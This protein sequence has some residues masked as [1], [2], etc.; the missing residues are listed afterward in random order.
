M[1]TSNY[2]V[3]F[4][5]FAERHYIKS[6]E[7]KYKSN[8]YKTRGDVVE[9]C[10]RIDTMIQLKRADLIAIS[11]SHKLVKLDFAVEG[12]KMSPKASGNRCILHIDEQLHIVKI[13][14]VYSKNDISPPNET[15]KWKTIIKNHFPETATIF[16][17]A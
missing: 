17:F 10:K 6:F 14:L 9:V 5:T 1:E 8:W 7:K 13:L 2:G 16:S 4:E 15:T 11:G 12:T 3:E